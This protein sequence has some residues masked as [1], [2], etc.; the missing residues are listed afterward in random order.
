M[1]N[2]LLNYIIENLR[3]ILFGAFLGFGF[4]MALEY[5]WKIRH[6]GFLK[7]IFGEKKNNNERSKNE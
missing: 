1:N 5:L 3:Y 2:I 4:G 6:K 7:Y